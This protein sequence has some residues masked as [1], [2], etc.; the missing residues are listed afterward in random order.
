LGNDGNMF[1]GYKNNKKTMGDHGDNEMTP[2][3]VENMPRMLGTMPRKH[4]GCQVI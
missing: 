2:R 3:D 1:G 4:Q